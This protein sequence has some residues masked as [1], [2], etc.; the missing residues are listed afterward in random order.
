MRSEPLEIVA[1]SIDKAGSTAVEPFVKRLN[2]ERLRPYLDPR[3]QIAKRVGEDGPAPFVLYGLPITYIIDRRGRIAG[4]L[5]GEA[6]WTSPA[7]LLLLRY[8]MRG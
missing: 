2:I 7:G 3:G 1:V 6:E 8:Y 4:Y 5:S